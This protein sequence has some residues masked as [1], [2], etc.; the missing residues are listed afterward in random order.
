MG[1]CR[2]FCGVARRAWGA[3]DNQMWAGGG[4]VW[5]PCSESAL[6]YLICQVRYLPERA[7]EAQDLPSPKVPEGAGNLFIRLLRI[8]CQYPLA[9]LTGGAHGGYALR[10]YGRVPGDGPGAAR[11]GC[12]VGGR[13]ESRAADWRLDVRGLVVGQVDV[14]MPP[15][16]PAAS[17]W[18]AVAAGGLGVARLLSP[19][20]CAAAAGCFR[21]HGVAAGAGCAGPAVVHEGGQVGGGLGQGAS[22]GRPGWRRVVM[23]SE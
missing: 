5:K 14:A 23:A 17:A 10:P 8:I 4:F 1:A 11:R 21:R 18:G 7:G 2:R 15:G 12:Y 3:R 19:A 13:G 6:L 16:I 20:G 22:A 9:I